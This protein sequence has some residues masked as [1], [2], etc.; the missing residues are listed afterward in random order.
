MPGVLIAEDTP[1]IRSA[2][3]RVV[4][5]ER[6]GLGPLYEASSGEEAVE[7]ARAMR[8]DIVLMDIQLR[9]VSGIEA[10]ARIKAAQPDARLIFLTAH[11][12]F[13]YAQQALRIGAADYLL[14]PVRPAQLVE[15]LDRV[16]PQGP[17]TVR[18]EATGYEGGPA[19]LPAESAATAGPIRPP[20]LAHALAYMERNLHRS[21]LR[22]SEVAAS[23]SLSASHLA[24]LIRQRL[25]RSYLAHLTHLRLERAKALLRS[26]DLTVAAVATAVGYETPAP[27]YQRFKRA[28][29]VTPSGFR[30]RPGG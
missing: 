13:A 22:L 7:L 20:A 19:Q 10:G 14:K 30:E 9:G 27:F 25:G 11:G 3:A 29:G 26:T 12:E 5:R 8:P 1:L 15:A 2:I 28:F 4:A 23:A 16:Q 24:A 6:P 17:P 18:P 21:D